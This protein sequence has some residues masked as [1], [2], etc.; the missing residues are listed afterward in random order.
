[1]TS[2]ESR[3]NV[4]VTTIN[5]ENPVS[6]ASVGAPSG[7]GSSSS[8]SSNSSSSNTPNPSTGTIFGNVGIR[9][10][11]PKMEESDES[12]TELSN[13]EKTAKVSMRED[14][15]ASKGLPR[16]MSW[17]GE[18]SEPEAMMIDNENSS[19]GDAKPEP[20]IVAKEE[21]CGPGITEPLAL[22]ANHSS[23]SSPLPG[24]AIKPEVGI[25]LISHHHHNSVASSYAANSIPTSSSSSSSINA[26]KLPDV[27][28]LKYEHDNLPAVHSPLLV[29]S[30]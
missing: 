13:I 4:S 2:T 27:I 6:S 8:S 12:D 9:I 3:G 10:T 16:P 20:L 22:T 17:E 23:S 29:H 21:P 18:L 24:R 11:V 30:N 28:N 1:M 15:R 7:T 19:T 26:K 5:C 14:S 25:P